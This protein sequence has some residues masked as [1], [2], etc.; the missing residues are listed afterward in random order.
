M[1]VRSQ[2]EA[3]RTT[4]LALPLE[5]HDTLVVVGRDR[6]S[7]LN[8][9]VTC[10]LVK[11]A[12]GEACYGLFVGRNGRIL[13]DA[14]VVVDEARVLM[15]IAATTTVGL[16]QH[17]DHYLV[18]ED[19]EIEPR[20]DAFAP[21]AIHGP[22]ASDVLAAARRAG[23]S[24]GGLDRTGL[25]GAV[26]FAPLERADD[27]RG[28][29]EETLS[30]LGGGLGDGAGWQALRLERAVPEL[31]VD[32]DAST[33]PQEA[34]LEK[35]AVSFDKGC[36]L[37]QEV[38]CMLEMRGHVRRVLVALVVESG[39]LPERGAAV[40]DED[41]TAAGEVTSAAMSP[42]L[43]SPVVLAMVKRPLA[44][45]GRIVRVEAARARVVE[46]PA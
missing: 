6:V 7:W 40:T 8:G 15:A 45:P 33:Y 32:F 18:M 4:A 35:T 46:R 41:G 14:R 30:R 5:G 23:G 39:P 11:R 22:A 31:G 36:Y 3:A 10:D 29:L 42:T 44:E 20:A 34:G 38:V 24:G 17:L 28:A 2:V 43:G 25:G 16:R 9:L 12:D 19:A 27:V 21:W 26:V 37:G 13:A 1:D